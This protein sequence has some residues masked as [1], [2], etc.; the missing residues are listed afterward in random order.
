MGTFNFAGDV[1]KVTLPFI[2]ALL[3]TLMPWRTAVMTLSVCGIA[4]GAV[5]WALARNT[6]TG[7][8][9]NQNSRKKSRGGQPM[10][11]PGPEELFRAPDDRDH[12]HLHPDGTSHLSP[13]SAIK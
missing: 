1:G 8:A 12:R 7:G 4:A 2:L 6:G 5:L 10:G 11:D 3:I 13:V 9:A